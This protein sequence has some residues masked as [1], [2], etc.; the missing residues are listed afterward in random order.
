MNNQISILRRTVH[1]CR[2]E[3]QC[4][5]KTGKSGAPN[6]LGIRPTRTVDKFGG[7]AEIRKIVYYKF[8]IH[9]NV[10]CLH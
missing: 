3:A 2:E 10:D 5:S 8:K 1:S 7:S 6:I 9:S 4:Q